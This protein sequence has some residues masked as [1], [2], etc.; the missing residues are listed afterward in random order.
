VPEPRGSAE[1]GDLRSLAADPTDL[2]GLRPWL[3]SFQHRL[4]QA[5]TGD[6]PEVSD[7]G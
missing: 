1:F 5:D 6:L 4:G 3:E 7:R 2:S